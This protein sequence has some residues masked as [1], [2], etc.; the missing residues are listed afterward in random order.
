MGGAGRGRGAGPSGMPSQAQIQAMRVRIAIIQESL[1]YTPTENDATGND[2]ANAADATKR[3]NGGYDEEY[4]GRRWPRR[5]RRRRHAKHGGNA[6]SVCSLPWLTQYLPIA[7]EMMAQMGGL[8]GG[9]IGNMFSKMMG[10]M[11]P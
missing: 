5:W 2:A 7:L 1:T 10:A 6:K 3:W 4:D 11:G 8:G 9:G